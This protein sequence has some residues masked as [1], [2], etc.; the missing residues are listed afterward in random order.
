MV[1]EELHSKEDP[2]SDW[3]E[4][5]ERYFLDPE[6]REQTAFSTIGSHVSTYYREEKVRVF[7][8]G[9]DPWVIA[10]AMTNNLVVV[11]M[12]K[13]ITNPESTS[14]IKIPNICDHFS[15]EC[16]SMYD[17]LLRTKAV[18]ELKKNENDEFNL[19]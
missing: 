11:S 18:L 17:C 6:N 10:S 19:I 16:I 3:I 13:R 14:K 2:L 12:E 15:V 8:S 7:L 4:K 1:F 5:R 9:A